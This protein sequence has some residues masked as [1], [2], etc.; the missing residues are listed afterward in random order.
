MWP[1]LI[2]LW[3]AL[4]GNGPSRPAPRR[5]PAFRRPASRPRLEALEDR[6]CPSSGALDPTFGSGGTVTTSLSKGP[7]YAHGVLLQSN[8][9]IIAYG[10]VTANSGSSSF[11]AKPGIG[12]ARYTPSGSLDTTFGSRGVVTT[13]K[14]GGT[15]LYPATSEPT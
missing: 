11:N 2:T 1:T 9:D 8:G 14:V 12:L 3:L 4:S 15:N 10:I 7:D 13:S 5:R 6:C